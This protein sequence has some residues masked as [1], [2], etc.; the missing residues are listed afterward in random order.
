MAWPTRRRV[1]WILAAAVLGLLLLAAFLLSRPDRVARFALAQ[2][3]QALGLE[4]TSSGASEYRIRGT[5]TLVVRDV[6]ARLP[7]TATPVL[8][9]DRV[10]LS[11][12][13]STLRARLA[14]L[15]FTRIELDAPVLHLA[16][17]QAWMASRPPGG[18]RVPA[19]G[20]GIGVGGGTILA[21]GWRVEGV[22]LEVPLLQGQ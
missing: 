9:A 13:W 7:G 3:G 20:E 6:V 10:L 16:A 12:P 1:A 15:D 22:G 11:M 4:I 8:A 18:G 5:P 21:D 19:L 17:F 14:D 2:A